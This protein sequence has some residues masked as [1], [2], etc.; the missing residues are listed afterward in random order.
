MLVAKAARDAQRAHRR[1]VQVQEAEHALLLRE[2][3]IR[4]RLRA[5]AT[6]FDDADRE[7][8]HRFVLEACRDLA[9]ECGDHCGGPVPERGPNAAAV[10]RWAGVGP[11]DHTTWPV[12][13]GDCALTGSSVRTRADV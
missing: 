1:H 12:H 10:L 7:I 3:H 13:R 6:R 2:H 11:D 9:R 5:G 8:L 4:S